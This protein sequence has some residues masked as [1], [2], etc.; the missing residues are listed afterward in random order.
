MQCTVQSKHGT[1]EST[2]FAFPEAEKH[3]FYLQSINRRTLDRVTGG[4]IEEGSV[5]DFDRFWEK[6]G[7]IWEDKL[8]KPGHLPQL[9]ERE[10]FRRLINIFKGCVESC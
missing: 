10:A 3:E 7:D 6:F 2:Y 4:L 1:I 8:P 5:I 9:T